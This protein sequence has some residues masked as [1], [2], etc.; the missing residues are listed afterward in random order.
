[1]AAP[2][3]SQKTRLASRPEDSVRGAALGLVAG[4][5]IAAIDCAR[6]LSQPFSGNR[7]ALCVYLFGFMGFVGALLG[8]AATLWLH[9]AATLGSKLRSP[10]KA[11][12]LQ[13]VLASLPLIGFLFWVPSSWVLANWD[14]LTRARRGVAIAVYV[15]LLVFSVV[16]VRLIV[17]L[18]AHYRERP[19]K[20]PRLHWPLSIGLLGLAAAFYWADAAVYPGLY[21][22]LHAGLAGST[23]LAATALCALTGEALGRRW[24]PTA[25]AAR[26]R[27]AGAGSILVLAL[28]TLVVSEIARPD[29]FGKSG[30]LVFSKALSLARLVTDFDG[31]GSPGLLGGTDCAGFDARRGV[32]KL[33]IPD[34]GVDEDCSGRDA[35]WPPQLDLPAPDRAPSPLN[36]VLITVDSL[37]A[38]HLSAYGYARNTSPHIAEWAS[39]AWRFTRA[40]SQ[41]TKT[42]ESTTSL[43]TGLYPSNLPRDYTHPR[44]EGKKDYVFYLSDD[45]PVLT[46]L[47]AEKGYSTRATSMLS[48]LRNIG[49]DRGFER[50]DV[51]P[52]A[53]ETALRFLKRGRRS[54]FLWVHLQWP[55]FPYQKQRGFDFGD[56]KLDRYDSEIAHTD[57]QI[58]RL[59]SLLRKRGFERNTIVALTSDHGEEFGEHGSYHHGGPPYRVQTHVPL[60]IKVP[61]AAPA[62]IETPV[63]LVD[64]V[65]TLCELTGF[66]DRCDGFDGQSLLATVA[67]KRAP[68]YPGAYA[69]NY[70]RYAG[71]QRRSL[72]TGR[73]RLIQDFIENRVELYD[74]TVDPGEQRNVAQGN[75]AIWQPLL[76]Q[77]AVRP[78]RYTSTLFTSKNPELLLRGLVRVRQEPLLSLALERVAQANVPRQQR[79]PYL[80]R[81]LARPGLS[82][83]LR[84]KVLALL[85]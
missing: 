42:W 63:E 21:P 46:E 69:E 82:S 8:A 31:D 25:R 19:G 28:A 51:S 1:M 38:D 6:S 81:L 2:I 35:R 64:L 58:G 3:P 23:A 47:L 53:I 10:W 41:D 79:E 48:L 54:F 12:W 43:F 73:W 11:R 57:A 77:L 17:R 9:L 66:L 20:L 45:A 34:N 33:D 18:M 70:H 55:H 50:F 84:S 59:L 44:N 13:A 40:F 5:L 62:V 68:E 37:R 16:S 61:R 75:E 7:F 71:V 36:L 83:E 27:A 78:L 74:T 14:T 4:L 65:P 15:A 67:G 85:R 24:P 29:I 49:L 39:G 52:N 30:A 72:F 60:I 32:G 56:A 76:E 22:D 26:Q 80:R